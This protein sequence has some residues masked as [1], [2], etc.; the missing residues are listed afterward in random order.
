MLKQYK[1]FEIHFLIIIRWLSLGYCWIWYTDS[2]SL[3]Q[4]VGQCNQ[5]DAVIGPFVT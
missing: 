1:N 4:H 3:F 5:V 2:M